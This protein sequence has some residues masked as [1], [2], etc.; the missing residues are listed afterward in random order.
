VLPRL[1]CRHCDEVIGVYEPMVIET[2]HGPQ[3]TSLAA[4]PELYVAD[5]P[6]FHRSCFAEARDREL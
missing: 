6:C 2:L 4:E 1:H 5:E 3:H